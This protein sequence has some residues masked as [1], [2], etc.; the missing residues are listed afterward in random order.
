MAK[1]KS[2]FGL[3]TGSTKSHTFSV[4][5]GEQITKDRVYITSNPQ[6]LNQGVIRSIFASASK[7]Y[8]KL[9]FI[10]NHSFQGVSYH[11]PS[12]SEFMKLAL[13]S[14]LGTSLVKGAPAYPFNY[15]I[16]KG[17]LGTFTA[18]RMLYGF[19]GILTL[20]SENLDELV[21][22]M[23]VNEFLAGCPALRAGDNI[24]FVG[25]DYYDNV[26][27]IT[28]VVPEDGTTTLE[29]WLADRVE[30][31]IKWSVNLNDSPENSFLKVVGIRRSSLDQNK[32]L[33]G[34]ETPVKN[35]CVIVSRLE[36]GVWK[37][38]TEKFM[39]DNSNTASMN[40]AKSY[41]K[42]YEGGTTIE[43]DYQ[44]D[45]TEEEM[46]LRDM[47][48][49]SKT[50]GNNTFLYQPE[51]YIAVKQVG[52]VLK[53]TVFVVKYYPEEAGSAI[54][55]IVDAQQYAPLMIETSDVP[56]GQITDA[57]KWLTIAD[58]QDASNYT[59]RIVQDAS[60]DWSQPIIVPTYDV[61]SND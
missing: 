28:F 17:S 52:T 43:S 56:A 33:I 29:D 50:F 36:N 31:G 61:I 42:G 25:W 58:L 6:S 34:A 26:G 60:V 24:T 5:R 12:Q 20:L 9:S 32:M 22:D 49:L 11:T 18:G 40:G 27:A 53:K 54:E 37:R 35:G 21:Y 45:E 57:N 46:K 39:Y 8:S 23:T 59:V 2:F 4:L 44:L 7:F 3:R 51:P 38:S 13:K 10:L 15:Q 1:S 48:L 41:T 16:S 14:R 47:L 30:G 19:D 55:V